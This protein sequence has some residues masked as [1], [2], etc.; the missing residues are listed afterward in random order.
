MQNKILI[1]CQVGDYKGEI[2]SKQI[3]TCLLD[4][5]IEKVFTIIVDNASNDV[6]LHIW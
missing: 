6:A 1:F 3:E 4:W 2:I 5:G